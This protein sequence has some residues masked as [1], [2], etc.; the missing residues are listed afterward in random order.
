[1]WPMGRPELISTWVSR[2]PS[3]TISAALSTFGSMTSSRRV[4]ALPTLS[5]TSPYVHRVS[6][7]F[8][9]THRTFSPQSLFLIALMTLARAE[10]FSLGATE[11]SRSKKTMS[12]TALG[13]FAR[14]RSDEPGVE[15]HDRRGRLRDRSDIVNTSPL[16]KANV[17]WLFQPL[18]T[19][20]R[21]E[22][23][24]FDQLIA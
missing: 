19:V 13:A 14:K 15:R 20:V 10:S 23:R 18:D 9:L 7:P 22:Q 1:M 6:Q 5:I 17:G 12:A 21:Y 2:R 4:P 24:Y 11:S 3:A 8:N 16:L